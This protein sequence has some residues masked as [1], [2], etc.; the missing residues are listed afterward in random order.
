MFNSARFNAV[1]AKLVVVLV[2]VTYATRR[3]YDKRSRET[4]Y[5][6]TRWNVRECKGNKG[7]FFREREREG[8]RQK[9][10]LISA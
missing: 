10:R 3:F 8:E 1:L 5:V 2:V 9:K 7:F 4:L 6:M